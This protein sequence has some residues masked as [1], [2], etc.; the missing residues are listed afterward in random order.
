MLLFVGFRVQKNKA[1]IADDKNSFARL[2]AVTVVFCALRRILKVFKDP[3]EITANGIYVS[4]TITFSP[5]CGLLI[6]LLTLAL[7]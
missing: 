2:V 4:L 6:K 1:L 7:C 3:S 5:N